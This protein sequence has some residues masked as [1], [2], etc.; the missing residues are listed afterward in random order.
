MVINHEPGDKIYVDFAGKKL[1]YHDIKSNQDIE[2]EFYAGLLGYSQLSFACVVQSQGSKDFLHQKNVRV[3]WWNNPC[4][5][6]RQP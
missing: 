6:Y 2:V 5:C 1:K 4:D 3:F